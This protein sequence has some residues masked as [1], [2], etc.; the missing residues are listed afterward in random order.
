M[1]TYFKSFGYKDR[2]FNIEVQE[3]EKGIMVLVEGED[4]TFLKKLLVNNEDVFITINDFKTLAE[5]HIDRLEEERKNSLEA[6]LY[7]AGFELC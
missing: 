7:E 6:K 2:E 5:I 1:A 4:F 3:L